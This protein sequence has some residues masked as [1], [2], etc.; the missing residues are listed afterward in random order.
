M[1]SYSSYSINIK[2]INRELINILENELQ[3]LFNITFI[4]YDQFELKI[5]FK[6]LLNENDEDQLIKLIDELLFK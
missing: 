2:D 5:F 1:N 6:T 4:A 3:K